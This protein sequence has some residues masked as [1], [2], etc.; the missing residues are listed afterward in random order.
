MNGAGAPGGWLR[1]AGDIYRESFR[2]IDA[3]TDFRHLPSGTRHVAAR[4]I[5]ACGLPQLAADLVISPNLQRGADEALA[6]ARPILVDVEMVRAGIMHRLLPAG[7]RTRCL[8]NSPEAREIA[9]GEGI[10]RSA[11]AVRLWR[12]H[13]DGAI[14]VIGNAPTALFTLVEMLRKGAPTPA[15][16]LAFPVGFVGAAESK[17]AFIALAEK[18]K[19]PLAALRGRAGGA[20]MAAAALNAL[21]I[22]HAGE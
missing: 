19:I 1:D 14:C 13:L 21:L 5:H 22:R 11:A 3:E 16:V 2:R 6:R 8:L 15:A 7:V 4:V 20:G 9:R 17:S 12:E 10:T 18:R